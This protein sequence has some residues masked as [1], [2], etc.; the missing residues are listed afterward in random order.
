MLKIFV[1]F[2]QNLT[3]ISQYK[4]KSRFFLSLSH[5]GRDSGFSSKIGTIPTKSGWLDRLHYF[6]LNFDKR[7]VVISC[8]I[9]S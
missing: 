1:S 4:S 5:I 2:Y 8:I 7:S 9:F 6:L 3:K